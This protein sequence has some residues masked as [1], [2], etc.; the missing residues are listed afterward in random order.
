[1]VRKILKRWWPAIAGALTGAAAVWL[2]A[3]REIDVYTV[4]AAAVRVRPGMTQDE[5]VAE[6][7]RCRTIKLDTYYYRGATK[8]GAR[9]SGCCN[10]RLPPAPDVAWAELEVCDEYGNELF[11]DLGPGGVVWRIRANTPDSLEDWRFA[12]WHRTG[13]LRGSPR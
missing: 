5:A 13:L 9:F 6:I 3:P 4:M 8:S 11:V 2:L 10:L 1:M 7:E 12:I